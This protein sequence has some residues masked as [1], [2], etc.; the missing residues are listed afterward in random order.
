MSTGVYIRLWC[1]KATRSMYTYVAG[2][3]FPVRHILTR[4]FYVMIHTTP[5]MA[6]LPRRERGKKRKKELL[7]SYI[8]AHLPNT[9]PPKLGFEHSK[10]VR[11]DLTSPHDTFIKYFHSKKKVNRSVV[12]Q[13][14]VHQQY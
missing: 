10:R 8:Y 1:L 5:H 7:R 13:S 9:T 4:F 6:M 11:G 2:F 14:T 3:H 12:V